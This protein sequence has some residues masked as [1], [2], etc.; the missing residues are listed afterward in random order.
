MACQQF[1]KRTQLDVLQH[2]AS[3]LH[4]IRKCLKFSQQSSSG[5]YEHLLVTVA[6]GRRAERC[7]AGTAPS[8]QL[9][10]HSEKSNTSTE[11][12]NSVHVTTIKNPS[13]SSIG[14]SFRSSAVSRNFVACPRLENRWHEFTASPNLL[15]LLQLTSQV[16]EM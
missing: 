7:A 12:G 8:V 5:T 16:G 14:R 13:E 3:I 4:A 6:H 9:R 10:Q 1:M 2:S 11:Q 15:S